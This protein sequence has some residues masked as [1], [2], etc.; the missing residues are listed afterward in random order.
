MAWCLWPRM[1]E[2]LDVLVVR[3]NCINIKVHHVG[4]VLRNKSWLVRHSLNNAIWA[5]CANSVRIQMTHRSL[6]MSL[7]LT[8][9]CIFSR[10][11]PLPIIPSIIT[12]EEAQSAKLAFINQCQMCNLRF[13]KGN[14][15]DTPV[16]DNVFYLEWK[17]HMWQ[18]SCNAN[19]AWYYPWGSTERTFGIHQTMPYVQSVLP[20][21]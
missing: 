19:Y 20:Q 4:R 8:E 11:H 17:L 18:L 21:G 7:I 10:C 15:D 5:I 1:V 13:P 6:W 12:L 9:K 3:T 16:L 2:L 14:T